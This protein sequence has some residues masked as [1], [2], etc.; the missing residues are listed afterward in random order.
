ML[1]EFEEQAEYDSYDRSKRHAF[2][3]HI[4]EFQGSAAKSNHKY[5][6]S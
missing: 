2:Q 3:L 1:N 5:D 4:S 6:G